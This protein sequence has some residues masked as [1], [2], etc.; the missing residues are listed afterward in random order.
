MWCGCSEG[1]C[2]LNE[3]VVV[4]QIV[5]IALAQLAITN[6]VLIDQ[7]QIIL[8]GDVWDEGQDDV[9]EEGA[10]IQVLQREEVAMGA[11]DALLFHTCGDE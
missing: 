9:E 10:I 6:F 5:I 7:Q 8:H 2:T 11:D 1:M 3:L 4:D